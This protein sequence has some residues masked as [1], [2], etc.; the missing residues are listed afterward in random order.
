MRN[1]GLVILMLCQS[2]H[3]HQGWKKPGLEAVVISSQR[4]GNLVVSRN[5]ERAEAT[6]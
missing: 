3:N 6:S 4:R 5:F 2:N 1:T